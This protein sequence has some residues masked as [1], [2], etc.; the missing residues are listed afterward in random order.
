MDKDEV[1]RLFPTVVAF[2]DEL[3]SEFG[4]GVKL[5]YAQENGREIG[6]TSVIDP[7][8]AVKLSEMCI[9]SHAFCVDDKD[10]RRAK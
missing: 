10:K 1:R 3:R 9:D 6:K 5:V 2:A 7:E 8:S 4:D